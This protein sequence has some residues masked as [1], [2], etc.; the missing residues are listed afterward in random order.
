MVVFSDPLMLITLLMHLPKVYYL[1]DDIL[2]ELCYS[3]GTFHSVQLPASVVREAGET[4][5]TTAN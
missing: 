5:K 1:L 3:D 4:I 2:T